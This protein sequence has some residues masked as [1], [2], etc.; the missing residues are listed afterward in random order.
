MKSFSKFG[1]VLWFSAILLTSCGGDDNPS[2]PA[3]IVAKWTPTRTIIS[4]NGGNIS[5]DYV[6]N[7]P[8]CDKDYIEFTATN[9]FNNVV[10]FKDASNVCTPSAAEPATYSK[11]DNSLVITGD[12]YGGTYEIIRLTNSEL[13]IKSEETNA[14]VTTSTSRYF[15]KVVE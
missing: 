1:L 8:G 12:V 3:S 2:T 9:A 7:E 14:G 10:F 6:G 4:A 15:R 13:R 11:T 5:S